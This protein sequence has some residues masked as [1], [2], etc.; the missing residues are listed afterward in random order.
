MVMTEDAYLP[1]YTVTFDLI[2]R[3]V[4]GMELFVP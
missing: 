2:M 3:A 4:F 1:R